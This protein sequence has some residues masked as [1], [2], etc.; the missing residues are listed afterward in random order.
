MIKISFIL[1]GILVAGCSSTLSPNIQQKKQRSEKIVTSNHFKIVD[2]R[3][4]LEKN[5]YEPIYIFLINVKSDVASKDLPELKRLTNSILSDFGNKVV[6]IT[7]P[8]SANKYLSNP[9][10]KDRFYIL[11][12]GIT[13]FDE[14][15]ESESSSLN[16]H[17]KIGDTKGKDK[18]KNKKKLSQLIGDFYL[19]QNEVVAHKTTSSI[20]IR[21]TNKGYR[22][23]INIYGVSIGIKSY[24]NIKDGLHLSV[25]KLVEASMIDLIGKAI[26]IETYQVMPEIQAK[27][28]ATKADHLSNYDFC[29][30]VEKIVLYPMA[31]EDERFNQ[32]GMSYES[33]M[34]KL[35]CFK[36]L[37]NKS[38]QSQYKVRLN[39]VF[40]ELTDRSRS[41]SN[42]KFIQRKINIDLGISRKNLLTKIV[43]NKKICDK[44]NNHDYCEFI[45]NRVELEKIYR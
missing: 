6:V 34:N 15:I 23:G 42:A 17:L 32:F 1:I 11:D 33:E 44:P 43:P 38:E 36:K 9:K 29:S 35:K 18:F 25:R 8:G 4:M 41:Y 10:T 31:L 26:G 7:E 19:K 37:Y 39:T 28:N 22:F 20:H 27:K 13:A 3:N 16:L 2:F 14:A 12:G 5:N 24:K 21:E 45:E 40:G 30:D